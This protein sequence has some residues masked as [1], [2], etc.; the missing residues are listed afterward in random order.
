MISTRMASLPLAA[1]SWKPRC[2]AGASSESAD[3]D[4]VS[5]STPKAPKGLPRIALLLALCGSLGACASLPG[6]PVVARQAG[7]SIT[8]QHLAAELP[9]GEQCG[10]LVPLS[11][12]RSDRP[13]HVTIYGMN[14]SPDQLQ[15]LTRQ[16]AAEGY[17]TMAF[18]YEDRQCTLRD[19]ARDLAGE[20]SAWRRAHPTQPMRIDAH[21]MGARF[22]VKALADLGVQAG[23]VQLN[24]LT[25]PLA[26]FPLANTAQLVPRP[27]ARLF[28]GTMPGYDMGSSSDYQAELE[29]TT[30]PANIQTRIFYGQADTLIDYTQPAFR[31]VEQNLRASVHYVPGG[32]HMGV[33]EAVARGNYSSQALPYQ[34]P[35]SFQALLR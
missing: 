25:P 31:A 26:G 20:L 16:A 13:T 18:V 8:R 7:E 19:T 12:Q 28:P 32:S 1:A 30:L 24:M 2:E 17:N 21:C 11:D 22:S 27:L 14:G 15:S 35:S 6:G 34:P 4:Q 3:P 33:I 23:T 9:G 10:R 5:L 29:R